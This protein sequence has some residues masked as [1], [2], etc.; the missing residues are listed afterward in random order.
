[1][2]LLRRIATAG[3]Q[4]RV[5]ADFDWG[6]L[7][8]AEQVLAATSGAPWRFGAADYGAATSLA[9]QNGRPALTGVPAASRWDDKLARVMGEKRIAVSEE[10]VVGGLLEDLA[11]Y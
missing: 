10:E 8:I 9:A 5:H 6:G 1:M 4:V 3:V 11:R 2:T 7:R